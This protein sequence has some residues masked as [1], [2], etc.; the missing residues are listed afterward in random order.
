MSSDPDEAPA[1]RVSCLC[2]AW[3]RTCDDYRPTFDALRE[4]FA[5]RADFRWL[6]IED[7]EAVL[8]EVDV[9]DFPTLLISRGDK[10]VFFGPVLPHA[11]TARQL[12]ARALDGALPS[13]GDAR[14]ANLAARIARLP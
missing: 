4:A 2:A 7:D 13:V 5:A 11:Q 1:W 9:Q 14:I 8:G 3:C 12:I 10:V 6:D